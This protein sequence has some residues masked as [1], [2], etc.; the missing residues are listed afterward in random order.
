M[1]E[2]KKV[3]AKTIKKQNGSPLAE[4]IQKRSVTF[5]RTE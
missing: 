1:A 4:I 2:R 5:P 3:G